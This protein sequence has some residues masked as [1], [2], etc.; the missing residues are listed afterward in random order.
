MKKTLVMAAVL[1]AGC[2][3]EAMR[4]PPSP[5][6]PAHANPVSVQTPPQATEPQS[7][8][9]QA[10]AS[11]ARPTEPPVKSP[12]PRSTP[13]KH[14]PKSVASAPAKSEPPVRKVCEIDAEDNPGQPIFATD[15]SGLLFLSLPQKLL[16]EVD[17][18]TGKQRWTAALPLRDLLEERSLSVRYAPDRIV[19][20]ASSETEARWVTLNPKTG[21]LV[22]DR[23]D[24]RRTVK[25]ISPDGRWLLRPK[26]ITSVS[27]GTSEF[28]PDTT[29]AAMLSLDGKTLA[30]ANATEIALIR[31]DAERTVLWRKEH[32]QEQTPALFGAAADAVAWGSGRWADGFVVSTRD[33]DLT[34]GFVVG[35]ATFLAF[36]PDGRHLALVVRD[37][38]RWDREVTLRSIRV[39]NL[40]G[41]VLSTWELG[42]EGIIAGVAPHEGG[43]LIAFRFPGKIVIDYW[44]PERR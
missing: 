18:L 29:E 9:P 27:D 8:P 10:T 25:M 12:E 30:T 3:G 6:L 20:A 4:Q 24:A 32:K 5:T 17:P 26:A 35:T 37:E 2:N 1:V 7:S 14:G 15:G 43:A 21:K 28:L 42:E 40:K 19:I 31:L 44:R 38:A 39:R 33:D 16:T 13:K 36:L 22:S 23:A 34:N 11:A 41:D